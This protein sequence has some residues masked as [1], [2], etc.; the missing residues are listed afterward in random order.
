M[1]NKF[2]LLAISHRREQYKYIDTM[3]ICTN[4]GAS[5]DLNAKETDNCSQANYAAVCIFYILYNW[6]NVEYNKLVNGKQV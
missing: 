2:N 5:F 4:F 1:L 6:Q 3:I